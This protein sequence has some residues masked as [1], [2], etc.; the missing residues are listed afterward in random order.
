MVFRGNF[1]DRS[2]STQTLTIVDP[3]GGNTAFSI[4]S[5]TAGLSVSP[6]TGVT[7]ATITVRADPNVFA[8]Q[9][10]TVT[11]QLQ[12][13]S[14]Q[15]VNVVLPVRVLI[16][17]RQP[18]Q[19][20]TFVN[21]PGKLVDLLSDPTQ[22]RFYLLR[23]DTNEVLVFNATNNT[24]I[25]SLRTK[26]TPMGMAITYDHRYLLVGHN[27]S[28]Y[29]SVFDLGSLQEMGPV[30]MFNGD[31]VQSLAASSNA[32]LAV[33]RNA[34][35]GDPNIH[36]IDL[37]SRSSSRLPSLGVYQNKVAV[38]SV[39]TASSNG[40]S[41]LIASSDGSVMLYDAN[42]NTFTV[43]RK[44]FSALSGAY[45]ASNFSQY[46][47]GNNLLDSS[48][49]PVAQLET[50]TGSPSG[51]GALQAVLRA[52][53]NSSMSRVR[54]AASAWQLR[55]PKRPCSAQRERRSRGRSHR[56]IAALQLLT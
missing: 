12:L 37:A 30:R 49:V 21:I 38:N 3:G 48:L 20:G 28:H 50:G 45:A 7:P 29:V 5:N 41:I 39:M 14:S 44:D 55:S 9:Q 26:N 13:Q 51:Q 47:V 52:S 18:A 1:C 4:S 36:R 43:S 23:Q 10:G 24:Q 16:N 27:N 40:S 56:C 54:A 8:S 46:I 22:D 17:S 6:S 11:A 25:T 2:V 31:Y 53:S 35:G 33:T 19:R 34:S 42:Q 15:A 32:I